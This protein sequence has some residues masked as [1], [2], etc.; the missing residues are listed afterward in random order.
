MNKNFR[1]LGV[2]Q[3]LSQNFRHRPEERPI[4]TTLALELME[5]AGERAKLQ[6]WRVYMSTQYYIALWR[7]KYKYI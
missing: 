4:L 3:P 5:I 1:F 2:V 6:H 7:F